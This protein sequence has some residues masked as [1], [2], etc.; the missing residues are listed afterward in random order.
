MAEADE[1]QVVEERPR[2]SERIAAGDLPAEGEAEAVV[3]EVAEPTKQ[4][5]FH[6]GRPSEVASEENQDWLCPYCERYQMAVV[7]P[8]C[9]SVVN[10]TMLPEDMAPRGSSRYQKAMERT[11]GEE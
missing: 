9:H 1:M 8:T 7:C 4:Y 6:C 2:L 11:G 10:M 5:C 3:K